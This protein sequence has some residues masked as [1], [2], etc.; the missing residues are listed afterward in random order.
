MFVFMKEKNLILRKNK[1]RDVDELAGEV[2]SWYSKTIISIGKGK[3]ATWK[4]A[5]LLAFLAGSAAAL[6]WTV[7]LNIESLSPSI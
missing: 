6:I 7:T 2:D 3:I 5:F 1:N 4:G